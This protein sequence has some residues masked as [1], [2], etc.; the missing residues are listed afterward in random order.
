MN[1][2]NFLWAIVTGICLALAGMYLLVWFRVRNT[3]ANLLFALG[4]VA[5]AVFA[6]IEP[7]MMQA[8]TPSQFGE[9]LRWLHLPAVVLVVS[10]VWFIRM[11][12]HSG[13]IWLA[14]LICG[15]RGFALIVNFAQQ[16]NLNF[17]E[18]TD[19]RH[20]MVLGE[21]VSVPVGE[22]SLWAN[23][24]PLSMVLFLA[25]I[26]DAAVTAWKQNKRRHAAVIGGTIS[27][28]I[29]MTGVSSV[30]MVR[31]VLPAPFTSVIVLMFVLVMAYELILDVLHTAQISHDLQET[32]ERMRLA[33][34]AADLGLWEWDVVRDDIWATEASRR[35]VG[36]SGS[37]RINLQRFLQSLHPD[38]REAAA[39][40]VRRSLDGNRDF[41]AEYR[42][43]TPEGEIRW[44]DVRGQMEHDA[45][46]KPV[47]IRGVSI[48]VT[49]RKRA[50]SERL[51]LRNELTHLNRV[52]TLS[53]LSSSLAHEV[54][55]PLGAI[56]N[57]SN[58]ALRFLSQSPPDL[59]RAKEAL[60]GIVRDDKR[61]AGVITGVR[62]LLKKQ[63]TQYLPVHVNKAVQ[64][65]IGFIRGDSILEGLSI[66]TD[67][68][69]EMAGMK[70]DHIQLEQV[71]LNLIL[72]AADAMK[73]TE[74]ALRKIVIKTEKEER[75]VKV[76][77]RDFG[78]GIDNA[79]RDKLFEPFFTTK[80]GGLGMGLAICARIIHDHEG[81]IWAENNVDG[82]A[83]FSFTLPI[84]TEAQYHT[85]HSTW[86]L[87]G[88]RRSVST[89]FRSKP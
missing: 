79:N 72:N 89:P 53:E 69:P 59:G 36:V 30:F 46:G 24:I 62:G 63:E 7:A 41:E 76:S 55:Q 38:D 64:E 37:E 60:E 27:I 34:R 70:G 19:L 48:D 86:R 83:T 57:Y 6:T 12:L 65:A 88:E 29:V 20:I 1:W 21:P 68:S 28:G 8:Q 9:Y 16:P 44:I 49:E 81:E 22:M 87:P 26:V 71:L 25:Y 75:G 40:D 4:A 39:R 78:E 66:E 56:L 80:P 47:R 10:F 82:G 50:E 58:A 31:G 74:S 17:R 13:R 5:A 84:S 51:E 54:N 42:R 85:E 23:L 61:A 11:Y 18:I 73:K 3:R 33:A 2:I 14:W 67:L 15:L 77:V 35:R 45:R 32:Q 52:M 43:V